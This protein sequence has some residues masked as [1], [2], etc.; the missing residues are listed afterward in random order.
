[1]K[2][3]MKVF[4]TGFLICTVSL[5]LFAG[6]TP[7]KDGN[8][9]TKQEETAKQTVKFTDSTGREVEIPKEIKKIAPSG[10]LAQIVLYSINPD[11]IAG[12]SQTPS[13]ATQKYMDEK[14]IN[15]PEFGQFYGKN[16]NMNMEAIVKAKPDV[17]ID[18]GEK[19]KGIKEDMDGLQKQLNIPVIF[20]EAT[21]DNMDKAYETLGNIL[22]EDT[23]ALAE[24]SKNT[25]NDAKEKSKTIPSDKKVKLYYGLAENGLNTI[26]KGSVH[27]AVID[28]VGAENVAVLDEISSKGTGNEVSMEQ[29]IK[30][31]PDAIIFAPD[32]DINKVTSDKSWSNMKAIKD[33]KYYVV[34][35]GPYNW[36]GSPPSINRLIGI[37]WLGN[38]LYPD[39]Y[40]YDMVKETKEFY[41][42]FYH[43]DLKDDEVKALLNKSTF[44]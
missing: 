26:G 17:I 7:K 3:L 21:L 25:V 37:K 18:I 19:K 42:L 41:K 16:A 24:Y 11:K 8:E 29:V 4:T 38:L 23:K 5:G 40:K 20:V 35:M 28:M 30:W 31:N 33:E 12:W 39:T 15:L 2:K 32:V 44:K 36:M 43:Y 27:G 1:M 13:K 14:Y 10:P 34:S 22:S 6:C 9:Q